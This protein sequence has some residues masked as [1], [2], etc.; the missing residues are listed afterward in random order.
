MFEALFILTTVDAGTR[1]ARFMLSDGLSNLGG[2]LRKLRNPSWRVGVWTCSL[3]VVA[4]WGSIL[5]MGVTDPLGGINTL[6]PLFGIANQL[7]AA[8]ALTVV[9]VIVIKKGLLKWVWIPAIPLLWDLTV[10]LTASWHKIF[11]GDPKVGYWTQHFQYREA[12]EAGKTTFGGAKNAD[13]ISAVI[14]NTFIQ[15]TL[16][17]VFASLVVIVFAAGLIMVIRVLHGGG[18]P[19]TEDEAVP[20]RLFAPS[21][22]YPTAKEREVQRQW[23]ALAKLPVKSVGTAAH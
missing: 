6:F 5:L 22:L 8:I 2:P 18:T 7:L 11:S 13:Q 17:I 23:D 16:S 15:G 4:A 21:G 9:S 14:R 10:T 1:V 19:L 3:I 12:A 20:S